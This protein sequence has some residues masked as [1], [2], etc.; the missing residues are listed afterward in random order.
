MDPSYY[1][2]LPEPW[3]SHSALQEMSSD[4]VARRTQWAIRRDSLAPVRSLQYVERPSAEERT[5]NWYCIPSRQ[6]SRTAHAYCMQGQ[7]KPAPGLTWNL[8]SLPRLAPT[9]SSSRA[10]PMSLQNIIEN[11]RRLVRVQRQDR[12]RKKGLNKPKFRLSPP[13]TQ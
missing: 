7:H 6:L 9:A 2:A 8:Q 3:L 12:Q 4:G 5:D 11:R 13:A 1:S 10:S